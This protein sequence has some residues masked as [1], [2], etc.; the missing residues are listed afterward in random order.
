MRSKFDP[1]ERELVEFLDNWLL[2]QQELYGKQRM[3]GVKGDAKAS[4]IF[5]WMVENGQYLDRNIEK[6]H[7]LKGE[8]FYEPQ[9][10][11]CYM[12]ALMMRSEG[13]SYW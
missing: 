5:A 7:E 3:W 4:D 12:N 6:T 8:A 13:L 9:L 10:K 1:K 11:E 2:M